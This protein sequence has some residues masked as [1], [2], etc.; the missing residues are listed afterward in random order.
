MKLKLLCLA[1]VLSLA[2]C[3][4]AMAEVQDFEEFTID[5]PAGWS[6][7]I[8]EDIGI[9][10]AADDQ[11]AVISISAAEND[12]TSIEEIAKGTAKEMGG[13]APQK[14]QEGAYTFTYKTE[15]GVDGKAIVQGTDEL[16][17]MITV[18]GD[19]PAVAGIMSSIKSK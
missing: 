6:T 15:D 18:T 17:V 7:D 19:N 12:G 1:F 16:C 2:L 10:V 5:V 14:V 13:T 3:V 9:I 8:D 11:S 4:P